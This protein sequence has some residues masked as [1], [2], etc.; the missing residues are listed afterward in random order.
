M[1]NVSE[2]LAKREP[3]GLRRVQPPTPP[4]PGPG[5]APDSV[6]SRPTEGPSLLP[7]LSLLH[8]QEISEVL[9]TFFYLKPSQNISRGLS[10]FPGRGFSGCVAWLQVDGPGL[11]PQPPVLDPGLGVPVCLRVEAPLVP[12]PSFPRLDSGRRWRASL[13]PEKGRGGLGSTVC[14]LPALAPPSRDPLSPRPGCAPTC[15]CG[16][17]AGWGHCRCRHFPWASF[18]RPDGG[19]PLQWVSSP[20]C[21]LRVV[22]C[23]LLK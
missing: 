7:G 4:Q 1:S 5:P 3:R 12:G 11:A 20:L 19:G 8:H 14:F 16:E 22:S 17:W 2:L 18:A 23:P 9:S 13:Y 10:V 6:T 21:C 15:L